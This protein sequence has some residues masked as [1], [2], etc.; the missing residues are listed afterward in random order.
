M[1]KWGL[2]GLLCLGACAIAQEKTL[3][4]T[5]PGLTVRNAVAKI[6]ELTD[7][8]LQVDDSANTSTL[9]LH[10][11]D[12]PLEQAL[13]KIAEVTSGYWVKIGDGRVL[14]LD[15][16]K[17]RRQC[18][19]IRERRLEAIQQQVEKAV[20]ELEPWP[21]FK[22]RMDAYALSVAE[23]NNLSPSANETYRRM[24]ALRK[25]RVGT[26]LAV[27]LSSLIDINDVLDLPKQSRVMYSN[28]PTNMQRML[29][30]GSDE[31]IAQF[32]VEFAEWKRAVLPTLDRYPVQYGYDTRKYINYSTQ[33]P[34]HVLLEVRRADWAQSVTFI[35]YTYD[36]RGQEIL[37]GVT[38]YLFSVAPT[39]TKYTFQSIELSEEA[40]AYPNFAR[41]YFKKTMPDGSPMEAVADAWL[42]RYAD[43]STDEPLSWL[44]GRAIVK[45]VEAAGDDLVA[46]IPDLALLEF[47]S[48]TSRW[49][50]QLSGSVI[51]GMIVDRWRCNVQYEDGCVS[52][53]PREP[54]VAR[55]SYLRR[56][57]LEDLMKAVQQDGALTVA[58]AAKYAYEQEGILS[59]RG[60]ERSLVGSVVPIGANYRPGHLLVFVKSA[61]VFLGSLS[62]DELQMAR[63]GT[64]LPVGMLQSKS[65]A[66][67]TTWLFYKSEFVYGLQH[68]KRPLLNEEDW[69]VDS[70]VWIE[71]RASSALP[72]GVPRDS[73]VR[74]RIE[75]KP[76]L[77]AKVPS[78]RLVTSE[79][80][81]TYGRVALIGEDEP[82]LY[83]PAELTVF[84]IELSL[85]KDVTADFTLEQVPA[86]RED[87]STLDQLSQRLQAQ[88]TA[89]IESA[90]KARAE[91]EQSRSR[92]TPPP[93][94]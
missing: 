82:R 33:P 55:S 88:I 37:G 42:D 79:A 10:L 47:I 72:D 16:G 9:V 35:A 53:S 24:L 78:R 46:L 86:F 70:P 31:A 71:G 89:Q 44:P 62:P 34:G 22:A 5:I 41:N 68:A 13:E 12:V 84:H 23:L 11:T 94:Q 51:G 14:K 36:D 69:E 43:C 67:L 66:A 91:F 81:E 19:A 64:G 92:R 52:L 7:A 26:R 29:P 2:A 6:A 8:K 38:G 54:A 3:T 61:L 85:G 60:I 93:V 49:Q 59:F 73:T 80:M 40:L 57:P 75:S 28:R 90:R 1:R 58:E 77:F 15:A 87:W 4:L 65:G 30:K 45:S 25:E 32:L 17:E 48:P 76:M 18:S 27:K 39:E 50:K 20:A 21:E 56:Q 63:S 74:I 83:Q